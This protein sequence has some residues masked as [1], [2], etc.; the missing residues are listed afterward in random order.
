MQFKTNGVAFGGAVT[1]SNATASSD[2]VSTLPHGS[3]SITA[4]YSGDMNFLTSTGSVSQVINTPPVGGSIV[5]ATTE[6]TAVTV[7]SNKLVN[8]AT[9]ADGDAL[10]I[11][12]LNSPTNAG[13]TTAFDGNA[14]VVYT[15]ASGFTGADSFT[16]VVS[17][18]FGAEATNTVNVT[19]NALNV[20][21]SLTN[22]TPLSDGTMQIIASGYPG[23]NYW[24][25]ATTNISIPPWTTIATNAALANGLIQFTDLCAPDYMMRFYRLAVPTNN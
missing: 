19:V 16:Y 3:N 21:A 11:T 22:I 1:L 24:I 5:L 12:A 6:N 13:A 4:E 8:V 14:N 17:D 10:A 25:Q 7:S 9:D 20:S 18:P 23:T 2:P 15:P